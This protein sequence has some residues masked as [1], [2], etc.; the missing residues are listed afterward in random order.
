MLQELQD[1]IVSKTQSAIIPSGYTFLAYRVQFK[2]YVDI[3]LCFTYP[4]GA[5]ILVSTILGVNSV[6]GMR[7]CC[8]FTVCTLNSRL[9]LRP[10][11]WL[12]QW[13]HGLRHELSSL[14]PTL[15]SSVRIPLKS[16]MSVFILFVLGSGLA[17]D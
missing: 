3:L 12:S 8:H 11:S 15:L 13:P 7:V 16:W 17:K 6:R 1:G 14:A 5:R 9:F 4:N 10:Q 2:K